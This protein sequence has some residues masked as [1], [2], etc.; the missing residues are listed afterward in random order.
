MAV[1]SFA[2]NGRFVGQPSRAELFGRI[3]LG[4]GEEGVR[5]ALSPIVACLSQR[6]YSSLERLLYQGA[7][8]PTAVP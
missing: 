2:E 4:H 1:V 3:C 7:R 5:T 8:A 6:H